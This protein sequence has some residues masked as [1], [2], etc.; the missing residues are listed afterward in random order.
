MI[1]MGTAIV[2]RVQE[3]DSKRVHKLV[4]SPDRLIDQG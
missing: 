1:R 2:G 4:D 3:G